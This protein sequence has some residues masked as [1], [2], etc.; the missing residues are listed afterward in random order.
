MEHCIFLRMGKTL[1]LLFLIFLGGVG[2]GSQESSVSADLLASSEAEEGA[3]LIPSD[4]ENVSDPEGKEPE[5]MEGDSSPLLKPGS[6]EYNHSG[7]IERFFDDPRGS[8]YDYWVFL[9]EGPVDQK[10]PVVVF[11]HGWFFFDPS[12]Y[13]EWINH[14]VQRGNIVIFPR[15]QS[16]PIEND[17]FTF[18]NRAL[19]AIEEAFKAIET[20]PSGIV[21][22]LDKVATVGYSIG[23]YLATNYANRAKERGLPQPQVLM[24]VFPSGV[25]VD[26][27]LSGIPSTTMMNCFVGEDD[28]VVGQLGCDVIWNRTSQIPL[29]QRDYVFVPTD[30]SSS[31]TVRATHMVPLGDGNVVSRNSFWKSLDG[32]MNCAFYDADCEYGLGDTEEH[33]SLGAWDDGRAVMPLE[34][35]D[36]PK[37]LF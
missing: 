31:A 35:L 12:N 30:S 8:A 14:M 7:V 1:F 18:T 26:L 33:R 23:G 17:L 22:D 20:D 34:I 19:S 13:Q 4:D 27:D 5:E 3:E 11:L 29:E 15:F 6:S 28:A 9:P 37:S 32:L 16:N 10:A 21:A 25:F 2:C 24:P 36:A